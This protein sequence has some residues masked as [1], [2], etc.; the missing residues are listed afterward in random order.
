MSKDAV[1]IMA[2]LTLRGVGPAKVRKIYSTISK[3]FRTNG[4]H[5]EGLSDALSSTLSP[6]QVTQFSDAKERA[7]REIDRLQEDG[8]VV[9]TF[10]DPDYP[11]AIRSKLG[12]DA[13]PILF[14]KGN[15]KLLNSPA[16]GLRGSRKASDKGLAA[17]RDSAT[18]R[19]PPGSM[20]SPV[21]LPE[22]T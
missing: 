14:C 8:I 10:L 4:E 18:G 21:M 3:L 17:T 19:R 11:A 1:N 16:V 13:P 5:K 20:L 22:S 7:S 6:Q 15:L 12:T 2:L 9:L